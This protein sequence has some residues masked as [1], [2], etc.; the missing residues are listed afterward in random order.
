MDS[1]VAIFR[2]QGFDQTTVSE[3]INEADVARGTFYLYFKNKDETIQRII[4]R[5]FEDVINAMTPLSRLPQLQSVSIRSA[6]TEL[7]TCLTSQPAWTIFVLKEVG[8][9]RPEFESRLQVFMDQ[10]V[11]MTEHILDEAASANKIK[12]L[13]A[14]IIS[15]VMVGSVRE[16]AIHICREGILEMEPYITSTI[17]LFTEGLVQQAAP[18]QTTHQPATQSTGEENTLRPLVAFH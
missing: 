3:I 8:G 10:V 7:V 9:Y 13:P 14:K 1:A 5:F 18:V 2:R 17:S 6:M 16:L 11:K 12:T 15:Q 4:D